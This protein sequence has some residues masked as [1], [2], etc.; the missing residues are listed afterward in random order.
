MLEYLYREIS[1]F[2]KIGLV[3]SVKFVYTYGSTTES[4]RY[5]MPKGKTASKEIR[6]SCTVPATVIRTNR[7]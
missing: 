5:T 6:Y 2:A 4:Q 1:F 7:Q 3:F